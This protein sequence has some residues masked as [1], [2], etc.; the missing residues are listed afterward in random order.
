MTRL[1]NILEKIG[2]RKSSGKE[3]KPAPATKPT[4]SQATQ[5]PGKPKT[6]A[7]NKPNFNAQRSIDANAQKAASTSLSRP[8][9]MPMVDVA[10]KLDD[11]AQKNPEKL[12]WKVSIVDLLKLLEI[13]SSFESRKEL[14]TELGCP[15]EL[16]KESASMNIWLHKTVLEKIAEN[17]GI[18]PKELLS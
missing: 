2:L 7:A 18:I 17:G 13:D 3:E 1:S 10:K 4:T 8:V 5:S 16:M 11:M 14:A 9:N 12:N 15:A 6:Q